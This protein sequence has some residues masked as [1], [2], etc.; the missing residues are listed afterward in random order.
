LDSLS[1]SSEH[2]ELI[3]RQVTIL[4]VLPKHPNAFDDDNDNNYNDDDYN[5]YDLDE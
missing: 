3:Y 1:R 4:L 5:D 2:L